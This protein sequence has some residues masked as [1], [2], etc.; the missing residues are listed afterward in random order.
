MHWRPTFWEDM[1]PEE[2]A[3]LGP[4]TDYV[5]RLYD[6]NRIAVAGGI[7]D[8]PGGIVCF[9][10]DDRDQATAIM[11]GDPL[12]AAGIVNITLHE[13]RAGFVGGRR[14]SFTDSPPDA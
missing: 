1:T 10:A 6:E 14:A 12:F 4:H 13:L 2:D 8:P 7:M 9:Y 5:R 3:L 11:E